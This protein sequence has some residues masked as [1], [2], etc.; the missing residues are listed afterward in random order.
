M[1]I[2]IIKACVVIAMIMIFPVKAATAGEI[3]LTS[4]GPGLVADSA[5]ITV[6]LAGFDG[7]LSFIKPAV[8]QGEPYDEAKDPAMHKNTPPE[9]GPQHGYFA[10]SLLVIVIAIVVSY[11][12]KVD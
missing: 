4:Q 6:E 2:K 12:L 8:K 11:F 10:V 7:F 9:D 5:V 1:L 3:E